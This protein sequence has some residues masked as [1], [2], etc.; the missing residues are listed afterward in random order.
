MKTYTHWTGR[1]KW[2]VKTVLSSKEIVSANFCK[3]FFSLYVYQTVHRRLYL[4]EGGY[5]EKF[6]QFGPRFCHN[7]FEPGGRVN[8]GQ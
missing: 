5:Q 3:W 6:G 8:D 1:I 4:K 2:N 7:S